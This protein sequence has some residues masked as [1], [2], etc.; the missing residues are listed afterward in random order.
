MIGVGSAYW[1]KPTLVC[2]GTHVILAAMGA[3]GC[4]PFD[5]DAAVEFVDRLAT[6]PSDVVTKVL[7]ATAGAPPE[8][9]IDIDEGGG[10]GLPARPSS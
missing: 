9:Y 8:N 6:S 10:A 2:F 5:N 7:R 4:G 3:W 1:A